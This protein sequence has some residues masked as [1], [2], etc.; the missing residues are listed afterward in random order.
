MSH[1][2]TS[3]LQQVRTGRSGP[4]PLRLPPKR[5]PPRWS[6]CG[7]GG[8]GESHSLWADEV[9]TP[10]SRGTR[11]S[12]PDWIRSQSING[13]MCSCATTCGPIRDGAAAG[14]RR[15]CHRRDRAGA[16]PGHEPVCFYR[17]STLLLLARTHTAEIQV[18][19]GIRRIICHVTYPAHHLLSTSL[20]QSSPFPTWACHV[21]GAGAQRPARHN[22]Q[23]AAT[24]SSPGHLN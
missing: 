4:L 16:T 23:H 5:R 3:G 19:T 14:H 9:Y 1:L 24:G 8:C 17:S 22:H 12:P 11:R 21:R 6:E 13:G 20:A 2:G 18:R 15:C 7:C 10:P